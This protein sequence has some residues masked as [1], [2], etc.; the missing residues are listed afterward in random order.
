METD[1][2][3]QSIYEQLPLDEVGFPDAQPGPEAA[4]R[5][6]VALYKLARVS[7]ICPTSAVHPRPY[8]GRVSIWGFACAHWDDPAAEVAAFVNSG[9]AGLPDGSTTHDVVATGVAAQCL[10]LVAAALE[11]AQIRGEGHRFIERHL[12]VAQLLEAPGALSTAEEQ[13]AELRRR[14]PDLPPLTPQQ[15]LYNS[16]LSAACKSSNL[17]AERM[18]A[19]HLAAAAGGPSVQQ[20]LASSAG[21]LTLASRSSATLLLLDPSRVEGHLTAGQL[22]ALQ[23][24]FVAA[25]QHYERAL[26]LARQ[27]RRIWFTV[28]A[29]SRVI[30]T[31]LL[32][33]GVCNTQAGMDEVRGRDLSAS[34]AP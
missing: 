3:L 14:H 19:A 10:H 11:G 22:A 31:R 18:N 15:L 25:R 7:H 24:N 21:L 9:Q 33:P 8:M 5:L 6:L 1:R 20:A 27:Q 12:A 34:H 29:A 13:L 30:K 23:R 32:L 4:E 2:L 17:V 28:A 26:A 16:H